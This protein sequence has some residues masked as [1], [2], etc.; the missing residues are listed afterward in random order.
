MA[1]TPTVV[2]LDVDKEIDVWPARCKR[3]VRGHTLSS[4]C[5]NCYLDGKIQCS[6]VVAE[7]DR[8]RRETTLADEQ[9]ATEDHRGTRVVAPTPTWQERI[10]ASV[11]PKASA[12]QQQRRE[13]ERVVSETEK[14]A[15]ELQNPLERLRAVKGECETT[16]RFVWMDKYQEL[17]VVACEADGVAPVGRALDIPACSIHNWKK[18]RG[19]TFNYSSSNSQKKSEG[20]QRVA[21]KKLVPGETPGKF[22]WE[23]YW[24]LLGYRD[25]MKEILAHP[26]WREKE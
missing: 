4:Q 26:M 6:P 10:R 20:C 15:P 11:N 18:A 24:K 19:I 16:R 22:P 23:E 9:H 21:A 2:R 1:E 17:L 12:S 7:N 14:Q 3:P 8:V 5:W 25:A 13:K